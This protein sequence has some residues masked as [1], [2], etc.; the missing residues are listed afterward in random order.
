MKALVIGVGSVG[1]R[2]LV[3][4]HALGVTHLSAYRTSRG[5]LPAAAPASVQVHHDLD[6]A[7]AQ[8][9]DLAVVANPTALHVPTARKAIEAGCHLYLEKPVSH[10]LDGVGELAAAARAAHRLV[11]VGCQRRFH[12]ALQAVKRWLDEGRIGAPLSAWIDAG[13]YL[14]D[15]HPDEDYRLGYAARA[16]LGGGVVLTQIHDLDLVLWWF[17][18]VDRVTAEGGH[19]TPLEIDVE[20]TAAILARCAS[21][22][23]VQLR[24]DYWRRPPVR[25]IQMCGEA[26]EIRADFHGGWAE[27]Q[28]QGR[29]PERVTPPTEWTRNTMF[30]DAMADTLRAIE[31]GTAPEVSLDQGIEALRLARAVLS[32]MKR[33]VAVAPRDIR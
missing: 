25:R 29:S 28:S 33:G 12:P 32:S 24:M 22:L 26:G 10:T 18:E 7:L 11:A 9:P 5:P 20:D 1:T 23:P 17:G 30:L 3:N 15:W 19:L 14:P 2:H 16:D 6:Q 4:L 13:E 8:G 27:I 31:D 21:G